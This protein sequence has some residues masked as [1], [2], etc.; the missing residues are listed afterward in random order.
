MGRVSTCQ[1]MHLNRP[2]VQVNDWAAGA[3]EADSRPG[4]LTKD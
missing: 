3:A 2:A 1:R 4:W